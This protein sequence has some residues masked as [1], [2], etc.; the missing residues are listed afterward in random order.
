MAC[1]VVESA[2]GIVIMKLQYIRS[3]KKLV[4]VSLILGVSPFRGTSVCAVSER[5]IR[6]T[7]VISNSDCRQ[8]RVSIRITVTAKLKSNFIAE[9]EG[10]LLTACI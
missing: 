3:S 6:D 5:I 4:T 1:P 10:V 7:S 2:L 9:Q 8:F